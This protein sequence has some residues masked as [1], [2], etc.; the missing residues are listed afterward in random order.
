[1]KCSG[2]IIILFSFLSATLFGQQISLSRQ[3]DTVKKDSGFQSK[4]TVPVP[5]SFQTFLQIPD[6]VQLAQDSIRMEDS[7]QRRTDSLRKLRAVPKNRVSEKKPGVKKSFQGKEAL[8]Y[9]LLFL[10]LL[11]GLMRRAFSKYFSDLFRVFFQTTLKQKQIRE[12]LLQTPVPSVLMNIF[13]VLTSGLYVNLLLNHFNL[14]YTP[15]FWMQYLYCAWAI[16]TIYLVKFFWLQISG[17]IFNVKELAN[18][19]TF[20]VFIVNK[21][22]GM[23]LLLFLVLI[24]FTQGTLNQVLLTLSWLGVA[25]LLVYRFILSYGATRN[26][27]KFNPFHFLLFIMAFEVIPL[28]LI[29][30]M[31]LLI[32]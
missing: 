24:P 23:Y 31:L 6:L 18:S 4:G 14:I 29:Y 12:Q 22:I 2:I 5:D 11:F 30:K 26:Q 25:G 9:Y 10:L 16:G 20:I 15:D 3:T 19:Y 21:V 13:F 28:L 1:M 32:F 27:I 7:I 8:F 17:W